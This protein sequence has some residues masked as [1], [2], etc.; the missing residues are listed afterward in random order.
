MTVAKHGV[1]S[2]S[3][4]RILIDA[5][6]VYLYFYDVNSPGTLLGATKGGNSFDLNRTVRR[7]DPDGAR[8][9][10][11][12]FRRIE[13]VVVAIKA[14]LLEMTA[15]NIRRSVCGA[16]YLSG[17]STITTEAVGTGNGT[18]K[19]FSL[20]HGTL[21]SRS[22]TV[23]LAAVAKTRMTDYTMDYINGQIQFF[24]APGNGVAIT[25]TYT[26]ASSSAVVIGSEV[27]DTD[28]LD[29]VAIIGTISG[30]TNPII[31]KITNALCDMNFTMPMNPKDETVI[32][33]T[34][35][36]HYLNTDLSTEPYSITY[37]AS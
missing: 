20:A 2:S 27:D 34:F 6:A 10:I 3:P 26:Y 14:N 28:F 37:P 17:T 25:C 22:E 30:M 33:V 24:T 4:G 13:D 32:P 7:I 15:E 8:G 11:R 35:T 12:G 16:A 5:G 1:T 36:A 21:A 23:Y 9:P 31:I 18:T 29:S 19:I